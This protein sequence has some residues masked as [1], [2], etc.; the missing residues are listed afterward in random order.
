MKYPNSGFETL[1]DARKWV[2]GFVKWYNEIKDTEK[3]VET[4]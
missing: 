4:A 2:Y 1:E 3:T